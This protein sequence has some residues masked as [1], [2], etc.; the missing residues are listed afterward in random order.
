ME[1]LNSQFMNLHLLF[2]CN[3]FKTTMDHPNSISNSI[4][5][6][7]N[8]II[9]SNS[10]IHNNINP[11]LPDLSSSEASEKSQRRNPYP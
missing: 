4:I 7:N 8:Y 1:L 2:M 10:I 3:L 9:Y 5:H 11:N 6:N